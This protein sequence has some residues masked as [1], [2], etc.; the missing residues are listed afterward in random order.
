[1]E[2]QSLKLRDHH[3]QE[4]PV[5]NSKVSFNDNI[6]HWHLHFQ[7]IGFVYMAQ[8]AAALAILYSQNS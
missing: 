3:R 4:Y 2:S 8:A 6:H 7:G 1:M 5:E